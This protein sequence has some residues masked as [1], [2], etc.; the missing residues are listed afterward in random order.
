VDALDLNVKHG[1]G[2]DL[3]AV[4]MR[5]VPRQAR[6]VGQ[7]DGN[8]AVQKLGIVGQR[9]KLLE[10]VQVLDPVLTNVLGDEVGQQRVAQQQP[11]PRRDAVGLVLEAIRPQ[12]VKVRERRPNGK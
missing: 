12:L 5:E 11:P 8:N 9:R 1:L 4:D 10:L 7:L 3:Q 2:Q 6:L